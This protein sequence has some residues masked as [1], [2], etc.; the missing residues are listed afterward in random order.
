MSERIAFLGKYYPI[1]G[2]NAAGNYWLARGLA[3]RGHEVHIITDAWEAAGSYQIMKESEPEDNL[4]NF[5]VHRP[6]HEIPWHI[7]EYD[8]QPLSLLDLTLDVIGKHSIEILDT[9]YLAPYG[10]VGHVAHRIT[11]VKHVLRHG[12]SDVE[13]FLKKGL[14]NTLLRGTIKSA[15][16]MVT[17]ERYADIF[18]PL[19][20]NTHVLHPYVVDTESFVLP[21]DGR[22]KKHLAGV[23]KI[24][25]YWDRKG[26]Q[27]IC[28]LMHNLVD[29]FDCTLVHQGLGL[30]EIQKLLG[31][32][33]IREFNWPGFMAPWQMPRFLS[34]LDALFVFKKPEP[35]SPVSNLAMEAL[36]AGVG[37]ITDDADFSRHYEKLISINEDQVL[38]INPEEIFSTSRAITNWLTD[39]WVRK[40]AAQKVS[41]SDYVAAREKIYEG[42]GETRLLDMGAYR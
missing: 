9:G 21:Y 37:I 29:A 23:G 31:R 33:T 25:Y 34:G 4:P 16:A 30:E 14:L 6:E 15:D 17:E 7:P 8:E 1:E 27:H 42:L 11:G 3:K 19:N 18:R 2:G 28:D 10:M 38:L 32:N 22:E 40:P 35:H 12:V 39:K 13:D 24:N 36:C 5:F 20:G 26:L 41:F